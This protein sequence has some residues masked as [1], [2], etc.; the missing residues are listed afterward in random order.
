MDPHNSIS[1]ANEATLNESKPDI[2]KAKQ[3]INHT[4]VENALSMTKLAWDPERLCLDFKFP[5][6]M[7]FGG[8]FY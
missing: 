3:E 1:L 4:V 7:K 8:G 5:S 6:S 2:D